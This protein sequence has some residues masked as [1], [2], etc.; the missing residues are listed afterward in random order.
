M[1]LVEK[2]KDEVIT[3]LVGT[4]PEATADDSTEAA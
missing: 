3:K 1:E 4:L 2:M